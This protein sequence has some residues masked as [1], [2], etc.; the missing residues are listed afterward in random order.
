MRMACAA[1]F[2][3]VIAGSAAA[4]QTEPARA[5]LPSAQLP[6]ELQ[7]V[8]SD[9]EDAWQR[10]DAAGL[11]R[12]FTEDGFLMAS[13]RP[14]ARGREA[15]ARHYTGQ[16]GGP[17]SLRAFAYAMQGDVGYIIGG[18]TRAKGEPDIGKFSLTLRRGP[19]GRWLIVTDMDNSNH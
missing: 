8:L 17:L 10:R 1:L 3:A 7:R 18:Y 6:A 9:Y 16:G 2:L 11:A 15:I 5:P 4:Q 13:G 12:L 19:E 14:P